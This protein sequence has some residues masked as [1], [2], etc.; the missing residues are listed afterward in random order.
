MKYFLLLLSFSAMADILDN[1]QYSERYYAGEY[2]IYDC[3]DKHW[4]CADKSAQSKCLSDRKEDILKNV[5]RLSCIPVKK[6]KNI[7]SCTQ[8]KIKLVNEPTDDLLCQ[9]PVRL[10]KPFISL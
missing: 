7:K 5:S 3:N 9:H 8:N 4:V 1:R 6:F 2:L 10:N